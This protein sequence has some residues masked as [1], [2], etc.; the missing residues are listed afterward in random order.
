LLLPFFGTVV[1]HQAF[2]ELTAFIS[3]IYQPYSLPPKPFTPCAVLLH[4][5]KIRLCVTAT[6]F[7]FLMADTLSRCIL[8]RQKSISLKTHSL[9][10]NFPPPCLSAAI[11][12]SS[13]ISSSSVNPLPEYSFLQPNPFTIPPV[14]SMCTGL[15]VFYSKQFRFL[16]VSYTFALHCIPAKKYEPRNSLLA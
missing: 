1:P 16:N 13:H 7:N 15:V 11:L 6:N 10:K 2:F 3:E 5:S 14:V 9:R 8:F 4:A 12:L